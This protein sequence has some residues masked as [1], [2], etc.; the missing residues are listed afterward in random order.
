MVLLIGGSVVGF[1]LALV[2]LG[3]LEF[4]SETGGW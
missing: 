3:L 2:I 1:C 4:R